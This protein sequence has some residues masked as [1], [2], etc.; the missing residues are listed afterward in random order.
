VQA[1]PLRPARLR[2]GDRVAV[3]APAG[4]VPREAF[5]AGARLLGERYRLSHTEALFVRSGFLAGDDARRLAEL[6]S[7][8]DDTSARAII[9]ARGGYGVLRLLPRL[10][11]DALVRDPRPVVGFS[12]VTALHA[13]LLRAGVASVH[14]PVVTQLG[15]IATP[16]AEL[17]AALESEEAPPAW[18]GLVPVAGGVAEGR[19]VGG[20]L[21]VLTRLLGTPYA[22]PFGGAVLFLEEVGERPYRIDRQLTHLRLAG[23][24]DVVAAVVVGDLVRCDE[25]DGSSDAAAVVAERL[26][27]LG[28]PVVAGAPFGHGERNR[29]FPHGARVRVDGD[30]GAVSFLESAVR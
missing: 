22:P 25:P 26:G 15:R 12:D 21:E 14:A 16:P 9:C 10:S 19:A 1:P 6:Q 7:A 17:F 23:A 5:D 2:P 20:N 30:A 3:V 4:P 24:L 11:L 27:A 28:V 29:P 13:A 18:T 8:V